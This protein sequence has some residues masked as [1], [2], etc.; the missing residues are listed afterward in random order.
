MLRASVIAI[1]LLAAPAYAEPTFDDVLIEIFTGDGGWPSAPVGDDEIEDWNESATPT[2]PEAPSTGVRQQDLDLRDTCGGFDGDLDV[3]DPC[4]GFYE[5]GEV[6]DEDG[7]C[8]P[9]YFWCEHAIQMG[10]A[11]TPEAIN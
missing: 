2:A 8:E 11:C 10:I 3:T 5:D 6:C 1:L 4:S 9:S 7:T